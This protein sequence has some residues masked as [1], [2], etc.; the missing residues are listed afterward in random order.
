MKSVNQ[1]VQFFKVIVFTGMTVL[2]SCSHSVAESG[3]VKEFRVSEFGAVGDGMANDGPAVAKAFEAFVSWPGPARLTF[4]S[5]GNYRVTSL[6]NVQDGDKAFLFNFRNVR[7]K[8]IDGNGC[9]F[10]MRFPLRLLH[11]KTCQEITVGDFSLGYDP[12]PFT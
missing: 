3:S 2:C 7:D 10:S 5:N 8:Y 6:P 9:H 12:A 4:E 11:I 1:L